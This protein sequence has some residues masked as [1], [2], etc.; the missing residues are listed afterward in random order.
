MITLIFSLDNTLSNNIFKLLQSKGY[1]IN[2]Q[3]D[4]SY[5]FY[6]FN[7]DNKNICKT[8]CV[9]NYLYL[10]NEDVKCIEEKIGQKCE[11]LII[12][13]HKSETQ[14]IDT[15][16]IHVCGNFNK[17][18]LGGEKQKLSYVYEDAFDYL[19][20]TISED[21]EKPSALEFFIEATHH[22]PSLDIPILYYEIGPN[23]D[24]YNNIEYQK[25]YTEKLIDYLKEKPKTQSEHY[26]LIGAPH[27]LDKKM[28]NNI[29]EK[30]KLKHN[31]E[32]IFFS[33]IVPKYSLNDILEL[34]DNELKNIFKE[35]I[36]KS[37]TNKLILNK[38]YM[39]SLTRITSILD[40]LDCEIFI[41]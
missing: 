33:H 34:D 5:V 40:K 13:T 31:K 9:E 37:L 24:A 22:G 25:Y 23:D 29:K 38:E 17:N 28:V 4:K 14:K 30:M 1:L 12:S 35:T 16:S 39:K 21:K 3:K 15:I 11:F 10:T 32:N 41:I 7:L 19:Y 2:E 27:Y 20:K 26:V 8:V 6:D 36:K 18:E